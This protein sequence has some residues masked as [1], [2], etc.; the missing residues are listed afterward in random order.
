MSDFIIDASV[1]ISLIF[2]DESSPY[3]DAVADSLKSGQAVA[4]VV[5]PLEVANSILTSVRRGRIPAA[6]VPRLFGAM[7]RL[8][9]AIDQ[10][11]DPEN[12]ARVALDLGLT[13]RLSAYDASYLDLAMRRGLPL[14]T[15]DQR[16]RDAAMA[17]G[18]QLYEP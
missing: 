11:I 2:E 3:S 16:L 14:A 9:V 5:R 1:A 15:L 10:G 17:A 12:V 8:R 4:P 13:Y 18:V 6:D 7:I